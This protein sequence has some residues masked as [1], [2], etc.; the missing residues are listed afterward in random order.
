MNCKVAIVWIHDYL[1]DD[2]PHDNVAELKAHLFS[3]PACCARL[4]QL[5]RTEA[6][7]HKMMDS[8]VVIDAG[9]S[10][11]LK[12]RIMSALP[13]KRRAASSFT[14]WIR[15]HPAITVAAVFALVMFASFTAM[16]EQNTD[17]TVRGSDLAQV[18]IEGDTVTVP[19]GAHINGDLT[20][21]NGTAN[22][23]GDVEGDVTVI[24]GSLYQ[25]ST[26]HISGQVK[27]I[28]QALDWFWYKVTN[29]MSS[30]AY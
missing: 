27:K 29:S 30:L 8:C 5:E 19:V 24:G 3:C 7:A 20:V 12:E 14:R 10:V 6:L 18:V 11:Q 28:D 21:S 16:W 9:H 1:D 15:N 13:Y 23:L 25:A 22:V 4:E 26:A 2:L 17:L